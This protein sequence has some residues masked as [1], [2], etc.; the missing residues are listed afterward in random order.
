MESDN[1]MIYIIVGVLVI[2][3]GFFFWSQS[4]SSK[5]TNNTATDQT[6]TTTDNSMMATDTSATTSTAT[7]STTGT[8][9]KAIPGYPSSWPS[10]VPKYP[11]EKVAYTGGNNPQS[12][13]TEATVVFTTT[14]SVKSVL[15][16]YLNGLRANGWTITETGNGLANQIT[17]RAK[18]AKRGVGGYIV[19]DAS[20]KTTVTVGVNIGI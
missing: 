1:K 8:Q 2:I 6:A 4:N 16:F 14:G 20:G 18:K 13:P 7:N 19:R 17:F 3:A 5:M 15:D 10:D 11:V 9:V 12:G